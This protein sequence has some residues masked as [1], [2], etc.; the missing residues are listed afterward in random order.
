LLSHILLIVPVYVLVI[1]QLRMAFITCRI[2]YVSTGNLRLYLILSCP[3]P[4]PAVYLR[5]A[6]R[7]GKRSQDQG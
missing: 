1:T 7:K 4:V 2:W 3:V 5:S 6:Q